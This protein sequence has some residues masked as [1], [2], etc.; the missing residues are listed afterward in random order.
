MSLLF[1]SVIDITRDGL[2]PQVFDNPKSDNPT[3]KHDVLHKIRHD[4]GRIS[5]DVQ[6]ENYFIKGSILTNQWTRNADID[7]FIQIDSTL[8]D[9]E[10]RDLLYDTWSE[11]DDSYEEGISHPFQYY[12]SSKSYDFDNTE[13]AYDVENLEWIKKPTTKSI[14]IDDYMSKYRKYVS[15]FADYSEELRRDVIDYEILKEIPRDDVKGIEGMANSQLERIESDII[16]YLDTYAEVRDM[17][18]A[19]FSGDMTPAELKQYGVKSKLPGNVI[20]KFIERYHYQDLAKK[21]R[22]IIGKDKELDEREYE[23]LNKILKT[24][25]TNE[26]TSFKSVFKPHTKGRGDMQHKAKHRQQDMSAGLK[27][28][29]DRKSLKLVPDYVRHSPLKAEREV[30]ND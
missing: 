28:I 6:V 15:K 9:D 19:A 17:R 30:D 24:K 10:L 20:F 27:G 1:E 16:D 8:T 26:T 7:I 21:L 18:Q 2:S 14:D 3:L 23:E 11:I 4:V 12:L 25:L 13:A 22:A 29:G 5:A